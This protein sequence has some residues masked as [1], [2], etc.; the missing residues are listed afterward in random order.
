MIPVLALLRW[1]RPGGR[2]HS[3]WLPLFLL[4]LVLLPLILILLP[5][6]ILVL[7]LAGARPFATLAGLWGIFT[8]LKGTQIDFQ[9]ADG[10]L[11]IHVF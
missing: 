7:A 3:L 11:V 4:W 6:L 5:V 2:R 10:I 9:S 1:R 8:A